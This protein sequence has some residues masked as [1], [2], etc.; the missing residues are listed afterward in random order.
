MTYL[1]R[2]LVAVLACLPLAA[3]AEP[4]PTAAIS[5][6]CFRYAGDLQSLLV[7]SGAES[8][9]T[10]ELSTANLVGPV[11]AV[12]EDGAVLFFQKPAGEGAAPRPAAAVKLP[13]GCTRAVVVLVPAAQGEALPYRGFAFSHENRAF[14]MGSMKIVNLSPYPVRW[15][16][17][18]EVMG[19]RPG[20]VEGF[21][22]KGEPGSNQNVV[23]QVEKDGRWLPLTT[24]RWA[25][26]DDRR[27]L[28][29]VYEDPATKRMGLRSIPDRT[30]VP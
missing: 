12:V 24:T 18:G 29:C 27:Y 10:V 25:V 7:K 30:L 11:K 19:L 4:P 15:N 5:V 2:L 20:G 23:F 14:P 8:T 22:P 28:M 1:R 26:R 21:R 13:V 16:I 6:F 9:E 3:S 17:G